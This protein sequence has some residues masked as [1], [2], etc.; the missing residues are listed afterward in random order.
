[1]SIFE[2]QAKKNELVACSRT[3]TTKTT[4]GDFAGAFP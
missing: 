2:S 4:M 3:P 1:M